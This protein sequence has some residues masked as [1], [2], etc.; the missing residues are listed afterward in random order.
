M[1]HAAK[2]AIAIGL[3]ITVASFIWSIYD[4]RQ[5]IETLENNSTS[6]SEDVLRIFTSLQKEV[7]T[8]VETLETH[9]SS[10][11]GLYYAMSVMNQTDLALIKRI[12][13]YRRDVTER[14]E[15]I[16]QTLAQQKRKLET[17][18]QQTNVVI[19]N[20]TVGALGSGITLK[21]KGQYYILTAGHMLEE[22]TDT[23]TF[24]E[25]GT[26]LGELEV[27]KREYHDMQGDIK[28]IENAVDLLL[29]RPKNRNLIPKVYV[30]LADKEPIVGE[31]IYIVGNPLGI[32][33]VVST[34]RII[35]Y[36]YN[37]MIF[38]DSTYFGNSGGGVYTSDGKLAGVV[39]F[40]D[41]LQPV[42]DVPPYMI[43]GAVRLQ[44]IRDFLQGL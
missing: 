20:T 5:K 33:D 8:C 37:F 39:S 34:G 13:L 32:E 16:P 2:I 14:I 31:E 30:E 26:E 17:N 12:E 25:N 18:L 24:G 28:G 22:D 9:S 7:E 36:E 38:K 1:R 11:H 35:Q 40:L 27:V 21:Y 43:F 10:L 6:Q 4:I 41:P 19:Y 15:N 23:L 42:K 3:I 44:T 29:T